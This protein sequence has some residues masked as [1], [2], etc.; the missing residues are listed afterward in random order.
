MS[1]KA[2][3]NRVR[4]L[5]IFQGVRFLRMRIVKKETGR[6]LDVVRSDNFRS[7]IPS[8]IVVDDA[9]NYLRGLYGAMMAFLRLIILSRWWAEFG[10]RVTFTLK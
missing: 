5:F 4:L 10:G 2:I 1:E 7:V 8:A 3:R 6:L 9:M